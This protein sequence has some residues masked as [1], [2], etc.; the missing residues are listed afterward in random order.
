LQNYDL[1]TKLLENVCSDFKTMKPIGCERIEGTN[2]IINTALPDDEGYALQQKGYIDITDKKGVVKR[3]VEGAI[4]E[5]FESAYLAGGKIY[6]IS[7][8]IT[9]LSESAGMF[10][11]L[12]LESIDTDGKN[13]AKIQ[14]LPSVNMASIEYVDDK[15]I[16][17]T[18]SEKSNDKS[19]IVPQ[20]LW[21]YNT[22]TKE[23][24]VLTDAKCT[25]A[26]YCGA[27][28]LTITK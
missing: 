15:M 3:V 21:V 17:L 28:F 10:Q 8:Q 7:G 16:L 20:D 18:L 12:Y 25:L 24:E 26:S 5:H 27:V 2:Y 23:L 14:L 4:D 13:R 9:Q 6:F 22:T 19:E 1:A 11:P